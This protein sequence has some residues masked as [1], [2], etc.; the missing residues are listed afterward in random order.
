MLVVQFLGQVFLSGIPRWV[1]RGFCK[2]AAWKIR[3]VFVEK[4][5]GKDSQMWVCCVMNFSFA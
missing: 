2:I 3:V 1:G 5:R 4:R